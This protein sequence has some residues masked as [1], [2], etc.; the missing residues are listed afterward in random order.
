[1]SYSVHGPLL[2]RVLAVYHDKNDFAGY[3]SDG[4]LVVL[5]EAEPD[6]R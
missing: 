4:S 6:A 5:S 3:L 1:M 2:D